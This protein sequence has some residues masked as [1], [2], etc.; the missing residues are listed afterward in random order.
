MALGWF[1][2]G[3]GMTNIAPLRHRLGHEDRRTRHDF[4][5]PIITQKK[6]E[7]FK[8]NL[9]AKFSWVGAEVSDL[10]GSIG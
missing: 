4:V 9:D 8:S 5:H 10:I 3:L 2:S 1:V 6:S 7:D